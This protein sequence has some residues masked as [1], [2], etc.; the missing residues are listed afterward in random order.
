MLSDQPNQFQIRITDPETTKGRFIPIVMAGGTGDRESVKSVY[1]KLVSD[2]RHVYQ[3][4]REHFRAL[5]QQTLRIDTPVES[6]DL[7]LEWSKVAYDN[8]LVFNPHLAGMGLIAGLD[9]SGPGGLERLER[10][11]HA[12]QRAVGV[13]LVL[14]HVQH[15]RAMSHSNKSL[16]L[17]PNDIFALYSHAN[18]VAY[19][20]DADSAVAPRGSAWRSGAAR[21]T[22]RSSRARS[23]F[24]ASSA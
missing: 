18:I 6:L 11:A 1:E 14:V 19:S 9:R 5:R 20:G 21:T 22:P 15:D 4:S 16:T 7:A 10:A 2:P 24:R 3:E 8:L 13:A 12:E 23:A 17:N